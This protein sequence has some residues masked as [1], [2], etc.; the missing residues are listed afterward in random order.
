LTPAEEDDALVTR[1]QGGDESAGEALV[2]RYWDRV[3]AFAYRLTR[4][5]A[6]AEDI[7]QETFLRAFGRIHEYTP[8]GQF[9]AWLLTIATN[10]FK[11]FRKSP[12]SREVPSDKID[13]RSHTHLSAEEVYDH[14]ELLKTLYEVIQTLSE[15]Q[16]VVLL[17]RAVERLDY[18]E[19]AGILNVKEATARWHMYEARR[20]LRQ[21][22]KTR[23]PEW[24]L[25]DERQPGS[26]PA[27]GNTDQSA[28]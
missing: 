5:R 4:D 6:D 2:E 22:L 26:V 15:D 11:D 25:T 21:K 7:A 3:Y 19:I 13:E 16:Q 1:C 10:L 27:D 14:R 24:G 23:F 18:P 20:T 28:D 8:D 9:K 12:K 17:L